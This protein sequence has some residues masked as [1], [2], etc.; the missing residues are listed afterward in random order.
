[1]SSLGQR[2]RLGRQSGRKAD[3][4]AR[5]AEHQR[6][7]NYQGS[8]ISWAPL[9]SQSP[10]TNYCG[11]IGSPQRADEQQAP[12]AQRVSDQQAKAW[13]TRLTEP[14]ADGAPRWNAAWRRPNGQAAQWSNCS[15]PVDSAQWHSHK[16]D[17]PLRRPLGGGGMV[18]WWGV[19]EPATAHAL[20]FSHTFPC[21]ETYSTYVEQMCTH[22]L[23]AHLSLLFCGK[24]KAA[25]LRAALAA[26][27]CNTQETRSPPPLYTDNPFLPRK[28]AQLPVPDLLH[29]IWGECELT[30]QR[31]SNCETLPTQGLHFSISRFPHVQCSNDL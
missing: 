7:E 6:M 14:K 3:E 19:C 22:M 13:S 24:Q 2:R 15:P 5:T 21:N 12:W 10:G 30:K 23:L 28:K 8:T 27:W 29:D 31:K 1:M 11:I 26:Q 9:I 4:P 17:I 20:G 16:P 25:V 18:Q